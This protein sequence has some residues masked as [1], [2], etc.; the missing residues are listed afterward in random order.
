MK[1]PKNN[2]TNLNKATPNL[3]IPKQPKQPKTTWNVMK[4]LQTAQNKPTT[5]KKKTETTKNNKNTEHGLHTKKQ[6][7]THYKK[8][9]KTTTTTKNLLTTD[10]WNNITHIDT[11]WNEVNMLR[12][13]LTPPTTCNVVLSFE[14]H[15]N[16]QNNRSNLNHV[17]N[18]NNLRTTWTTW[19]TLPLSQQSKQPKNNAKIYWNNQTTRTAWDKLKQTGIIENRQ[20]KLRKIEHC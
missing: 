18:L 1:Q 9:Q 3:I 6:N 17:D 5:S 16:K 10:N 14:K 15:M 4:N 12:H 20:D 11:I 8:Q 13:N 2:I 19:N 7:A